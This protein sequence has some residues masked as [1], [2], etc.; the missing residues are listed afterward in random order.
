MSTEWTYSKCNI[1]DYKEDHI[2]IVYKVFHK[3]DN[4]PI[5]HNIKTDN[6]SE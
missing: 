1:V 4:T 3:K 6:W 5:N 2:L